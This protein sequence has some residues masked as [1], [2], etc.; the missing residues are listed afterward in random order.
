MAIAAGAREAAEALTREQFDLFYRATAS[1]LRSYIRR[2]SGDSAAADDILQ[3]AYIR[4]LTVRLVPE[5]RKSYL[6]RTATNLV[7]DHQRARNRRERWLWFAARKP[8]AADSGLELSSDIERL[9]A[10]IDARERAL[11][12]LAYVEGADHRE[13]AGILGLKANSI[14]VLLFRA[15][16]KMEMILRKHGYE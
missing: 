2:V 8:E 5:G 11:L 6:Y 15:R 10:Q 14:R 12:W 13:I 1:G 7:I 16:R 4:L 9:F 3:E